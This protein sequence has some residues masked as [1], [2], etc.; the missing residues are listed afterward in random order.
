MS[1]NG[2]TNYAT[3]CVASWIDN[4]EGVYKIFQ[5]IANHIPESYDQDSKRS[6]VMVYIKE[7]VNKNA[8]RS[9]NFWSSIINDIL[10]EQINYLEIAKTIL[11]E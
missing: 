11:N 9:D 8:P 7:F 2:Y 4:T 10:T 1:H 3:W 6:V 5:N